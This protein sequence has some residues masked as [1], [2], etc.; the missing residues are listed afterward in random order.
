MKAITE[1]CPV[2]F[3]CWGIG[4]HREDSPPAYGVTDDAES[5]RALEEALELGVNFFDTSGL[6]GGGHSERLLG[7]VTR[8]HDVILASKAGY[9]D[10][11]G[12]QNFDLEY[13]ARALAESQ[14]R[15]GRVDLFQVHDPPAAVLADDGFW[16]TLLGWKEA[17]RFRYLGVSLRR[18]A[19]AFQIVGRI[20]LDAV[21]LNYSLVDQRAR[22]EGVLAACSQLTVIA[23]TPLGFGYLAG[24]QPL[25]PE[26]HRVRFSERQ[27]ELWEAARGSFSEILEGPSA[28]TKALRFCLSYPEVSLAIPGMLTVEHVRDNLRALEAP[29]STEARE[30]AEE[31]YGQL[32]LYEG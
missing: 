20:P 17:G 10:A 15:L 19:D 6:Y 4:G 21:Q 2:G 28:A 25:T 23:R 32:T 8:G 5:V 24:A 29:L 9:A 14:D 30:A 26:D 27:R 18:P 22:L 3:G 31:L 16:Q 7:Q 11:V 13:L 12:G 1:V